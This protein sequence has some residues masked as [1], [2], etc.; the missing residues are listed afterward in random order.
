VRSIY[1]LRYLRDPQLQRNVQRSQN[2]IESYQQLRSTIAQAG[3]K[4]ALTGHDAFQSAGQRI[5]LDALL[6]GLNFG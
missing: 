2:R 6:A 5:G 4:K 1:T 3:G